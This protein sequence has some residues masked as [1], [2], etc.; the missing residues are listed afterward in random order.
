MVAIRWWS[1]AQFWLFFAILH[2]QKIVTYFY[3]NIVY[4]NIMC[5]KG[6]KYSQSQQLIG[7]KRKEIDQKFSLFSAQWFFDALFLSID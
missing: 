7:T 2:G 4:E 1:S 6:L 3:F 5:D